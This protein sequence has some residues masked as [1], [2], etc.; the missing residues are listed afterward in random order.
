MPS[1]DFITMTEAGHLAGLFRCRVRR[2]P[3]AI[4]YRQYDSV[5][6][7]W[8]SF[9]W[10]ETAQLVDRWQGALAHAGLNPGDRVAVMLRNSVEWLLFEQA[11]LSLGL[12]VV[13]IYNQDNA[14]NAAY[15]IGNSGSRLVLV[16]ERA[17]WVEIAQYSDQ[18]AELETVV[19]L[20]Q[21]AESAEGL[22]VCHVEEWLNQTGAVAAPDIALDDLA[23]I[24]Y[25][26]GTTGRPKGV[27][28]SH[29]NILANVEAISRIVPGY[30][31][32]VYLSFL[33][34]SHMLERTVGYYYPMCAGSQV[35]FAR[36]IKALGDDLR[37]IRPTVLVSVPRMFERAHSR[38]EQSLESKGAL[39]K[40]LFQLATRIG[41]I[42][43]EWSQ[44]RGRPPSL[45]ERLLWR[46]LHTL[47][48]KKILA[49]LGGR[50][51]VVISGGGPLDEAVARCFIGFGL[52]ILQGYGLTETSPVVSGN[53][54]QDNMPDSVGPPLPGVKLR[55]GQ[56]NELLV[57][58][59]T[60]MLGYWQ[61]PE[62]TAEVIDPDGWLHTG[63]IAEI[64]DARVYIR[65][66]IKDILVTST[67]EKVPRVDLEMAIG[68]D[69]L[70]EQVVVVGEGKPYLA[71]LIVLRA[72]GWRSL[73][74]ELGVDA[75]DPASL[76]AEAVKK[77]VLERINAQLAAF[78]AYA[79]IRA[80]Y[81]TLEPW[82]IDNG[83]MTATQKLRRKQ[84]MERYQQVIDTLY[85]G[86]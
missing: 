3:D 18:F 79:R 80:V 46:V 12:V 76:N 45:L 42:R 4:A 28:L 63:D 82:T 9:S 19:V 74:A 52:P 84:I 48:V 81:L 75:E 83:F 40:R 51:R 2:T 24:V 69:T 36:S 33:P 68:R 56:A 49:E 32:D 8:L 14:G 37:N 72:E 50:L 10:A 58:G 25:T 53:R 26:S 35:V 64:S 20:D 38:I 43:F 15:I 44:G 86:H 62:A 11:A 60:V 13:P 39:A 27:M 85:T 17:Q 61:R 22:K 23:T 6:S 30:P 70:S 55:L 77:V 41:N 5:A 1:T 67:G 16:G 59:P 47:V 78:P 21:A 34:L 29:G 71:A 66:R 57:A 31:E 65:G 54:L 73:A 7:R